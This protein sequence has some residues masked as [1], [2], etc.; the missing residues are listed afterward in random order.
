MA[1]P[2]TLIPFDFSFAEINKTTAPTLDEGSPKG[3]TSIVLNG[4]YWGD[5]AKASIVGATTPTGLKMQ[6]FIAAGG[7]SDLQNATITTRPLKQNT[8]DIFDPDTANDFD[9]PSGTKIY[10]VDS[11]YYFRYTY[12]AI[13]GIIGTGAK[14]LKLGDGTTDATQGFEIDQ[15]ITSST[16]KYGADAS[17]DPLITKPDGSSFIPGAGAGSISGGDG[18]D[19]TASVISVDLA[20]VT[21]F[22]VI[23]DDDESVGVVTDLADGKISDTFMPSGFVKKIT[24]S[25][26]TLANGSSLTINHDLAT[27][28]IV[29]QF[30]VKANPTNV[31]TNTVAMYGMNGLAATA[32]KRDNAE[33][34]SAIDLTEINAPTSVIGFDGTVDGAY[35]FASASSQG[36]SAPNNTAFQFGID[37]FTI[38]AWIKRASLGAQMTIFGSRLQV[39]SDGWTWLIDSL[40][41]LALTINGAAITASIATIADTANWH[42]VAMRR[43]SANDIN[44]FID[45]VKDATIVNNGSDLDASVILSIGQSNIG[46]DFFNGDMDEVRI[47]K[48]EALSDAVIALHARQILFTD[49]V[50]CNAPG[51]L[52]FNIRQTDDDNVAL[53]NNSGEIVNAVGSVL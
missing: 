13:L 9:L 27:N 29:S 19:L 51:E 15:G 17:G 40:N 47:T 38:E 39:S 35:S 8:S 48:G 43:D 5:I 18:I 34:T 16:T 20:D 33:T 31:L 4:S 28:N 45:G 49:A 26:P 30:W 37:V 53:I 24:G 22:R 12:E 3:S 25:D 21:T 41:R 46:T 11:S 6:L 50:S 2:L 7:F 14:N 42:H 23:R 32:E 44:Y 52:L 10:P 1:D 36:A